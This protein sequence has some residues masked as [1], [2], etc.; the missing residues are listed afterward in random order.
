M[1]VSNDNKQK[2]VV[3]VLER[4]RGM[5]TPW[6]SLPFVVDVGNG[7]DRRRDFWHLPD[8]P[9]DYGDACRI[10]RRWAVDFLERPAEFSLLPA[11]VHAM[12]ETA[13]ARSA[14][15]DGSCG[16]AVGFMSTVE[17]LARHIART[18]DL[19]GWLQRTESRDEERDRRDADSRRDHAAHA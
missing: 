4:G 17:Q 12:G 10:G 13:A 14:R 8:G 19:R 16:Y 3:A 9:V 1:A 7:G 6:P 15:A 11:I 18:S 2:P 5:R